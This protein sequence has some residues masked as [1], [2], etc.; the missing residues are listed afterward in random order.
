MMLQFRF[1]IAPALAGAF[2]TGAAT[3][4]GQSAPAGPPATETTVPARPAGQAV[5][6]NSATTEDL[7]KLPGI[8][9]QR[10][11]AIVRARPYK[12]VDDLVQ[13]RILKASTFERI[14]PYI[15]AN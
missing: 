13:R 2:L 10:A 6:I 15:V 9:T 3:V 4:L 1:L 8:T 5:N 11:N 7:R 12:Q 14:K